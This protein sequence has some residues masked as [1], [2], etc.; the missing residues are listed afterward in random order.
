MKLYSFRRVQTLPVALE[1]IWTFVSNPVNLC[2]ITPPWLGLEVVSRVP[3]RIYPGLLVTYRVRPVARIPVLWVTEITQAVEPWLFVD[4][5]RIG[6]YRFWHHQHIFREVPL[7]VEVE[8]IVHYALPL[9]W[10]GPCVNRAVAPRL[11][12]IFDY[13]RRAL[14]DLFAGGVGGSR[15]G[16]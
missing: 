15:H 3:E 5:Q 7:G 9:G 16:W 1:T 11:R 12:E 6:P 4:E 8:D 10:L 13:R 14:E 2:R